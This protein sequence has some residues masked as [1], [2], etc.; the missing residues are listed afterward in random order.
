[1]ASNFPF[2]PGI[3]K[4]IKANKKRSGIKA[5]FTPRPEEAPEVIAARWEKKKDR[6]HQ[7]AHNISRL[8]LNVS[9]D[10]ESDNE[11]T[12]LIALIIA[13]MDR[14]GERIGNG[15]SIKDGHYGVTYFK[16][17]HLNIKGGEI[18]LDYI[19]KSGVPHN[20]IFSNE[21]V[22]KAL[23]RAVKNSPSKYIFE[24]S[25]GL[26]IHEYMVNEYLHEFSITGKDI[27]GYFI[28]RAMTEKL[29]SID[30]PEAEKDRKRLFTKTCKK[31]AAQIGHG[32]G[33]CKKHY[34]VPELM[35]QYITHGK[36]IDL[37]SQNYYKDGGAI[38]TPEKKHGT[39]T[40]VAPNNPDIRFNN[41]GFLAPNG[42]PS[43]LTPEQY[44]LVRTPEFI[45]W[46]GDW[47]N[48][49]KN[50]SKVVDEN[51]EPLVVWKGVDEDTILGGFFAKDKIVADA[52]GKSKSFFLNFVDPYIIDS[53]GSW[54][55]VDIKS[56][57]SNLTNEER[58]EIVKSEFRG[59]YKTLSDYFNDEYK[60]PIPIEAVVSFIKTKT[61]YDGI[62]VKEIYETED[63]SLLTSDYISFKAEQAKLADGT[64]TTFAP[65]N[66]DI[67]YGNGGVI[68]NME[69]RKSRIQKQ[70][71][72]DLKEM[73]TQYVYH[74]TSPKN[75]QDILQNGLKVGDSKKWEEGDVDNWVKYK[76]L[77]FASIDRDELFGF[78]GKDDVW[79]IEV[80]K[81]NNKWYEDPF[82]GTGSDIATDTNIP[83]S[84]VSL[85]YDGVKKKFMFPNVAPERK[86]VRTS[87]GDKTY[88]LDEQGYIKFYEDG[89]LLP[90]NDDFANSEKSPIFTSTKI[91]KEDVNQIITGTRAVTSG[92]A[93]QA[94]PRYLRG[95]ASAIPS[96][97][98]SDFQRQDVPSIIQI[99]ETEYK[100]MQEGGG[101][102][103]KDD[104]FDNSNKISNFTSNT[105]KDE[106]QHVISGKI[107]V[108]NG[109]L[110]QAAA[111]YLR[112]G[113]ST[114]FVATDPQSIQQAEANILR[115]FSKLIPIF[116][117]T[118]FI[119]EGTEHRVYLDGQTVLKLNS[120]YFYKSWED[121]FHSLLLHNY[122]FEDTPYEL[123]GFTE[124]NGK[125][126]SVVRQKFVETTKEIDPDISR[127]FLSDN[128]FVNKTGDDYVHENTGV[129]LAD[130]H[131][132]NIIIRKGVPFFI[133]T[134]FYVSEKTDKFA[135]ARFDTGG[136]IPPEAK[137][138]IAQYRKE[139]IFIKPEDKPTVGSLP[140]SR[141]NGPYADI[142]P[143]QESVYIKGVKKWQQRIAAGERPYV[144]IDYSSRTNDNRVKDGHHRLKAYELSGITNIPVI[145]VN[146]RVLNGKFNKIKERELL[147]MNPIKRREAL[148]NLNKQ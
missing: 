3:K 4:K 31:I 99:R 28:N 103:S 55:S 23:K 132:Q 77:L 20:P 49:P 117:F 124:E 7:L 129:I 113:K 102:S 21:K 18:N 9:K 15:K 93:I 118:N 109:D 127:K 65:N 104:D 79:R 71:R 100:I 38:Q 82:S 130:L 35:E 96:D 106:I 14:T 24:T 33:T 39:D 115:G 142:F 91:T 51:G 88:Y 54:S 90:D 111:N 119:G 125:L 46:F 17:S 134:V 5:K 94:A 63:A 133:D 75:R 120:C 67:R 128:G 121:Y 45:S 143:S 12:A 16:K 85:Y 64:N 123:M 11:R 110:I 60:E 8:R 61:K 58:Y 76:N 40:T 140:I 146:G 48:D 147:A 10:L 36:I 98:G 105:T 44:K 62:V 137:R 139:G 148:V 80:A 136:T 108:R 144:L 135:N 66:P 52:F 89:G 138:Q 2:V 27:R 47:E 112:E 74:V 126:F 73:G 114:G 30:I 83:A 122:L 25:D 13:L 145:D 56:E 86:A 42:K 50:A 53:I 26:K 95:S 37:K 107:K 69:G 32:A 41:G 29:K 97:R 101:I 19:G 59:A 92:T 1:M 57:L 22:A 87:R 81:I 70:D 34:I 116:G 68:W 141:F 78:D 43:N 131:G 72:W 6:I 84:E